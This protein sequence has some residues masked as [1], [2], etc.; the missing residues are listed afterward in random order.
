[1]GIFIFNTTRFEFVEGS[2]IEAVREGCVF[3]AD[4]FNLLTESV[5][6]GLIPFIEV[7]SGLTFVHPEVPTPITVTHGYIFVRTVNPDTVRDRVDHH[8]VPQTGQLNE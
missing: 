1:M 8:Q 2:L 5:M 3:L 7:A 6:L 4:E